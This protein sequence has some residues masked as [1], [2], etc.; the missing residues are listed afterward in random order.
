MNLLMYS[1]L[2]PVG[3]SRD[4]PGSVRS[5]R[6]DRGHL[7]TRSIYRSNRYGRATKW[8]VDGHRLP[9]AAATLLL[10]TGALAFVVS[11]AVFVVSPP[12]GLVSDL[13]DNYRIVLAV[14]GVAGGVA[15]VLAGLWT[16]NGQPVYRTRPNSV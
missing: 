6:R 4:A 14:L 11:G 13:P 7:E 9:R 12:P 10:A 5:R 16:R 15:R 2:A 3:E 8:A 1:C